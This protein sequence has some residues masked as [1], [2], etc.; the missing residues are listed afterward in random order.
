ML[1]FAKVTL[2]LTLTV[3][4]SACGGFGKTPEERAL[5]RADA[6]LDDVDATDAQRETVRKA[7]GE[8]TKS[9]ADT[10]VA[11]GTTKGAFLAQLEA[12]K[13]D[14]A[15]VTAEADKMTAAF[16]KSAHAFVDTGAVIHATLTPAQR[17]VLT[18]KMKPGR[19]M[20][21]AFFV[22]GRMGYG[23]PADANEGRERAAARLEKG[24]DAIDATDAQKQALRPIAQALVDDALPL[25]DES[26]VIVEAFT[27]AWKSERA[28]VASLHALVDTETAKVGDV[29]RSAADAF[30]QAHAVLTPEQ[31]KDLGV[32]LASSE[33][34]DG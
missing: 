27:T 2:A 31:R 7:V 33:G 10:R 20:K 24:L 18:K 3:A 13:A 11:R 1:S 6:L 23:P 8:L 17:D 29:A 4:A 26:N 28:D 14:S 21:A 12:P 34:C 22:A 32:K 9:F 30:V 16:A 25:L 19:T 15:V 5:A